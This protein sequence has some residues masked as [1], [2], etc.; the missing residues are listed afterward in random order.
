MMYYNIFTRFKTK[1][2]EVRAC[3]IEIL[4]NSNLSQ[5]FSSGMLVVEDSLT[6][7]FHYQSQ[8]SW[9]QVGDECYVCY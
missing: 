3:V 4:P 9:Q 6:Q 2:E 1:Q 8:F 7:S 5:T